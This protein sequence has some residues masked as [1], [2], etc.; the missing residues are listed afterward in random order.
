MMSFRNAVSLETR[1][2]LFE[3]GKFWLNREDL[4]MLNNCQYTIRAYS[5]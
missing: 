3:L 1:D 4:K 5:C 2:D